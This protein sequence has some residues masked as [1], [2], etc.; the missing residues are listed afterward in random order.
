LKRSPP[1]YFQDAKQARSYA[2]SSAKRSINIAR[3]AFVKWLQQQGFSEGRILEVGC[4]SGEVA[5]ELANEFPKATVTGLDLSEPMLEMARGST[6][7]AGLSDRV[8]FKKGDIQLM[9]F[10]DKS[11]DAIVSLNTF[12]VVKDPISMVNEIERVLAPE[13]CLMVTDIRRS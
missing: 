3:E 8:L 12:H 7:S 2:Q 13:G 10:E 9:P 4:G 1:E 5:I 6:E 11:F